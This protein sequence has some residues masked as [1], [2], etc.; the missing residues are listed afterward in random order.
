MMSGR[1]YSVIKN[2]SDVSV[3]NAAQSIVMSYDP[4]PVEEEMGQLLDCVSNG[5]HL[6]VSNTNPYG[7]FGELLGL[8]LKSSLVNADSA[9]GWSTLYKRGEILL[10]TETKRE[11]SASLRLRNNE[12]SWEEWIYTP[13]TPWN[14]TQK[15]YL[16]I[17]VYGT[18]GGSQW[19]LYLTDSNG[20]E[21]YYR[22]DLSTYNYVTKTYEPA[23]IGWKLHLIPIKEY[24]SDLDLSSVQKLRIV[25][26][27]QLPLNMLVDDIFV[28][29]KSSREH[30][31]VLA[32]GIQGIS[33]IDLP[34][35]GVEDLGFSVTGKIVANYTWN[36]MSVTPFAIQKEIGN[37][38]VTYLNISSLY[39]SIISER[40][41]FSS[42]HET[43]FT[44]LAM[45]GV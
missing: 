39:K 18:G 31:T 5:G 27:F 1:S 2:A 37:G 14:L 30:S 16:G 34:T 4:L 11:G 42:P 3:I 43:L 29:Q 19:Y 23:F 41:V 44:I 36:G 17:W 38:K 6:I 33:N 26:G 40:S 9:D 28:L 8:T 12:S 15:D 20:N 32:N 10:E 13:P 21:K 24:F 45:L 22:Y 25:T 7:M 35:I